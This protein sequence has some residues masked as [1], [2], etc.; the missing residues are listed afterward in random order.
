MKQ[1]YIMPVGV[2]DFRRVREQ[3]YYVDKTDFIKSLI[4]SHSQAT[5]ITRP[6]RFGKTLA[7]SM[8]YYFFTLENAKENRALFEGTAIEK[9][10]EKYMAFQG[11]K[12]TVF[13]SLK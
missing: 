1:H 11:S 3:Y 9:A 4:D 7:L 8:L 10:G 12:P 6:R 5:L 2:D 13:V